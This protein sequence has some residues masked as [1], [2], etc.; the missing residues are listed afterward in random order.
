MIT[1]GS[2]MQVFHDGALCEYLAVPH[3]QLHRLP[4]EA[5]FEMGAIVEP[6]SNAVHLLDRGAVE[7]GSVIV[8]FGTGTIGLLVVQAARLA[9]ARKVIAI[10][11]NPFRLQR[12]RE[13][14]ADVVVNAQ[15]KDPL[16]AIQAETDGR[17][18]DVAV[19]AAGFSATYRQCVEAVR[20]RGKVL[21]LGFIEP[22]ATFPMHSVIY[23]E[24][25]IIGCSAFSHE[26]A[27]ALALIA[28]GHLQVKP[29]ITHTFPLDA[30]QEAFETAADPAA[31]SIK[32]LIVP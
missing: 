20:K 27:T 6:A 5:S 22:E 16:A 29:L 24:L 11:I 21:A 28:C 26:V 13:L 18:A 15:D 32:V 8:V 12:A 1:L 17:G 9:G 7:V 30:A 23:R 31:N 3:R 2:A 4:P 10:D 19:E 14:G 25:S